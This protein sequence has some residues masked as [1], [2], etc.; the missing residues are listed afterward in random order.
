MSPEQL[1]EIEAR[2]D[3]GC[4]G[5]GRTGEA[6]LYCPCVDQTAVD[7]RVLLAEVRGLRAALDSA[8]LELEGLP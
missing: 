5:H 6:L 1:A 8:L 3:Q 7:V 4:D 2:A